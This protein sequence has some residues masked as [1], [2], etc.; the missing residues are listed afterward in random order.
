MAWLLVLQWSRWYLH[1]ESCLD[2]VLGSVFANMHLGFMVASMSLIIT[3]YLELLLY[4]TLTIL[5]SNYSHSWLLKFHWLYFVRVENWGYVYVQFIIIFHFSCGFVFFFCM[6][7][8]LDLASSQTRKVH[9]SAT[10]LLDIA[11]A[12]S[13]EVYLF[14]RGISWVLDPA[15]STY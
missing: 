10:V 5:M 13:R 11:G 9:F 8:S 3:V 6:K 4:F 2:L 15:K 14:V 1:Y 7:S 12:Q